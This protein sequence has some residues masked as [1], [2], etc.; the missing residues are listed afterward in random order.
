MKLP[1]F[2]VFPCCRWSVESP[3][4]TRRWRRA[5]AIDSGIISCQCKMQVSRRNSKSN[6]NSQQLMVDFYPYHLAKA[7]RRYWFKYSN[8][9]LYHW[10]KESLVSFHAD[11]MNLFP[12]SVGG[13]GVVASQITEQM[14]KLMS[15]CLVVKIRD[16]CLY[17]VTTSSRE[18]PTP[19]L[20][21]MSTY[22][23]L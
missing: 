23:L 10:L 4:L 18:T 5:V 16:I 22:F 9:D 1:G 11:M 20:C 12:K 17:K 6:F 2:A 8:N 19:F 21:S 13:S 7:D 14:S 15:T 3:R